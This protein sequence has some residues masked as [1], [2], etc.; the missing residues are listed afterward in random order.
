MEY[1]EDFSVY[2]KLENNTNDNRLNEMNYNKCMMNTKK[3]MLRT[4]MPE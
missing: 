3:E 1:D 4:K 2:E